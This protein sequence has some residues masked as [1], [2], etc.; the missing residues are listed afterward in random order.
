MVVFLQDIVDIY[1]LGNLSQKIIHSFTPFEPHLQGKTE[2]NW[3]YALTRLQTIASFKLD[4]ENEKPG[5][6]AND[7]AQSPSLTNN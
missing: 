7:R 6:Q 5:L 1:P 4:S 2:K 3:T